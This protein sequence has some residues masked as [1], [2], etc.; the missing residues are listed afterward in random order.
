MRYTVVWTQYALDALA[1]AWIQA[2]DRA[3]VTSASDPVDPELEV[4][5]DSKGVDFYGDRLLV[6]DSFL[7]VIF[8][9]EPP[10]LRVTVLDVWCI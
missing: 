10:K 5:P 8:R 4:N 6:V 2:S 1:D 7:H 9:V 3:A